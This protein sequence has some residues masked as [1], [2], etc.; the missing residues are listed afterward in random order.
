MRQ[1]FAE[2]RVVIVAND[3]SFRF[4]ANDAAY[5]RPSAK[6]TKGMVGKVSMG[7]AVV[8]VLMHA[9]TAS[10]A[11]PPTPPVSAEQLDNTESNC[12]CGSRSATTSTTR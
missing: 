9:G 7:L 10:A 11:E 4:R 8:G 1:A 3:G 6:G 2:A 12:C 5:R